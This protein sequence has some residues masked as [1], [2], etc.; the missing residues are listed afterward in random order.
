MEYEVVD[1]NER[2][3]NGSSW[4]AICEER[5]NRLWKMQ[6]WSRKKGNQHPMT[7]RIDHDISIGKV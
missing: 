2:I 7:R 1:K 5:K 3:M 6:L 4:V